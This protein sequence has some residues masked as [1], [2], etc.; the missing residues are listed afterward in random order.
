MQ[1][2]IWW[3][4]LIAISCAGLAKG[5]ET[6]DENERK[7]YAFMAMFPDNPLEDF[8]DGNI[9]IVRH[10]ADQWNVRIGPDDR[11]HMPLDESLLPRLKQLGAIHHLSVEHYAGL[12]NERYQVLREL[13]SLYSLYVRIHADEP[14]GLLAIVGEV[15]G[16]RVF[17]IDSGSLTAADLRA[18]KPE[19]Q[20]T[21]LTLSMPLTRDHLTAITEVCPQLERLQ[22]M[23]RHAD[24]LTYDDLLT[25]KNLKSLKTLSVLRT[26]LTDEEREKLRGELAGVD[27]SFGLRGF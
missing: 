9:Y 19:N 6:A 2:T 15:P 10:G 4:V 23:P 12:P 17:R 16:L 1:R 20:L 5:D 18:L 21:M 13:K 7:A 24:E 26:S 27:V 11:P 14:S 22:L 25:L 8:F 3:C